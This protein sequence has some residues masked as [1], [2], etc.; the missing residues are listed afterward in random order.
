[1]AEEDETLSIEGS[2]CVL[3]SPSSNMESSGDPSF[4]FKECKFPP[5]RKLQENVCIW[6]LKSPAV[7]P[8][9]LS[10]LWR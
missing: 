7:G 6:E 9:V 4:A 8:A 5:G 2:E 3:P 10:C 1:M